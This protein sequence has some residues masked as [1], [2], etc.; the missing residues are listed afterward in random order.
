MHRLL[1]GGGAHIILMATQTHKK[2]CS[3][4]I[5]GGRE[6]SPYSNERV[7]VWRSSFTEVHDNK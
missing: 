7:G 5:A 1:W 3:I 6:E 2:N 4:N